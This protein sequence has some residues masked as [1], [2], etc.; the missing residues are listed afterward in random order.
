MLLSRIK[1]KEYS[2]L[3]HFSLFLKLLHLIPC[4]DTFTLLNLFFSFLLFKNFQQT[5]TMLHLWVKQ[6]H[7]FHKRANLVC[8]PW[9]EKGVATRSLG[10]GVYLIYQAKFSFHFNAKNDPILHVPFAM[11]LRQ[12]S[13]IISSILCYFIMGSNLIRYLPS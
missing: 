1:Q 4:S 7:F 9:P 3:L 11:I 10:I 12:Q 13:Y 8:Q 5:E 2:P 6:M